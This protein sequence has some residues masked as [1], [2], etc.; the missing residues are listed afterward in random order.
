MKRLIYL[1][2]CTIFVFN[3]NYA[4]AGGDDDKGSKIGIRAGWQLSGI[5]EDGSLPSGYDANS[6]FYA[7]VFRDTKLI[8]LL[9]LGTGIEYSQVGIVRDSSNVNSK[10]LLHYLAIPI[11]IKVK[12]GPVF[13]LGGAS[14]NFRVADT[15]TING[16][17]VDPADGFESNVFDVP[18]F[19]GA[20][21]KIFFLTIEARYHWGMLNVIGSGD[22]FNNRSRYL[23]LGAAISF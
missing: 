9:R 20:G 10:I 15:R 21:V 8:P 3:I 18:L 17:S 19:L 16:Q 12:L 11:D 2:L 22:N 14:L 1:V 5:Y 4:F 23:Q 7:G 13:V 6:G